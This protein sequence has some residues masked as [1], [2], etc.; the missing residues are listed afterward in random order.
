MKNLLKNK[1]VSVLAL[2][3]FFFMIYTGSNAQ[4]S[5][6]VQVT[7]QVFYDNLQPYGTWIDYPGYGQVWHPQLAGDFRP[8]LTNGYWDFSTEGWMWIS[9]YDWGWAPFHYGRWIYDDMYGWLWVPGYVQRY[10]R[11]KIS[12]ATIAEVNQRS[13]GPK[14]RGDQ[15]Q[16][17]R[18]TITNPQPR[19][20]RRIENDNINPIRND[21]DR[22][23]N[24]REQQ[25]RNIQKLPVQRNNNNN[26]RQPRTDNGGN[27]R[28]SVRK[29]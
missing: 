22:I 19:E 5:T 17:Y 24:A 14:R 8:Y 7:Y 25:E 26:F 3:S 4:I 1:T 2:L 15:M 29:N 12:P 28:R 16:V 18:P 20:Y 11:Q 27:G 13:M 21:R 10:T 6:R 23:N 9:N